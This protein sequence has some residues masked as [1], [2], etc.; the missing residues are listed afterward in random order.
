MHILIAEPNQKIRNQFQYH[1]ST[2][3]FEI[4]QAADGN[5]AWESIQA[6]KPDLVLMQI[7]L[8]ELSGVEIIRRVRADAHLAGTA[9]ICFGEPLTTNE[10]VDLFKLGIDNYIDSPFSMR[11]LVAQ[12]KAHLRRIPA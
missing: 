11:L 5:V 6:Q 9:I 12:V 10:L 3:G 8:P 4:F 7:K 1:L 2:Q